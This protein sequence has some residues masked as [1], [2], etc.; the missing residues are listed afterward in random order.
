MPKHDRLITATVAAPVENLAA[1]PYL[2]RMRARR[3]GRLDENIAPI[4]PLVSDIR[5]ASS[6]EFVDAI[7]ARLERRAP[8]TGLCKKAIQR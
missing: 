6:K 8:N 4:G 1:V 3:V 2:L 5:T 7:D